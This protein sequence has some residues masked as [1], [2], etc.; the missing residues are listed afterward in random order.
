MNASCVARRTVSEILHGCRPVTP[1]M[2]IRLG[3]LLGNGAELWLRMQ[4]AHPSRQQ[5]ADV[6]HQT[7]LLRPR[8]DELAHPPAYIHHTLQI[9]KQIRATLHLIQNRPLRK[10]R[11]KTARIGIGKR[12][13]L[14][15]FQ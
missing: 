15:V 11:Q 5:L 2:A 8:E 12:T 13:L 6:R 4:Q 3:K 1:D 10:P 7:K 14:W 9:R